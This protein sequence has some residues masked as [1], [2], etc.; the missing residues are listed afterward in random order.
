[1]IMSH[2]CLPPP[3]GYLFVNVSLVMMGVF[4]G[5]V[6]VIVVPAAVRHQRVVGG[7]RADLNE[8]SGTCNGHITEHI[9]LVYI[10][11]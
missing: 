11:E 6:S 2:I 5:Q 9:L 4:V 8:M 3:S 10:R 7:A 1:M